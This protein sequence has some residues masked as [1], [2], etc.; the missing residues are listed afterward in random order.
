MIGVDQFGIGRPHFSQHAEPTERILPL[1]GFQRALG[2]RF[3]AD[4]VIAIAAGNE[5]AIDAMGDAALLVGGKRLGTIEVVKGDVRR[6][7]DRGQSSRIALVHLIMRHFGLAIDGDLL[8]AGQRR[9]I[10]AVQAIVESKREACVRQPFGMQP[11]R[12]TGLFQ[13]RHPTRTSSR[14]N[15]SGHWRLSLLP[16]RPW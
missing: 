1:E 14:P 11:C 6:L 12:R 9:Q 4:A 2:N 7:I 15:M 10:D 16:L 13:L 5:L 3:T 8:A